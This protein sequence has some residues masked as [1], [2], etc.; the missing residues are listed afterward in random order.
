MNFR[1]WTASVVGLF[2]AMPTAAQ[3]VALLRQKLRTIERLA[4]SP[5]P[6]EN[7]ERDLAKNVAELIKARPE[8]PAAMFWLGDVLER[9]G[10][11]DD[12]LNVWRRSLAMKSLLPDIEINPIRAKAAARVSQSL[13]G[14]NDGAGAETSALQ[15]ME[16]DPSSAAGPMALLESSLRTG[17]IAAAVATIHDAAERQGAKAPAVCVIDHDALSRVGEWAKLATELERLSPEERRPEDYHHFKGRLAEIAG[18]AEE[19][20]LW[21]YLASVGGAESLPTTLRS[22]DFIDKARFKEESAI[23]P[24]LLPYVR[25]LSALDR[26]DVNPDRRTAGLKLPLS[27]AEPGRLAGRYLQVRCA[28]AASEENVEAAWRALLKDYP[29]FPP[30]YCG[31]AE[32]I[33][34]TRPESEE[35]GQLVAKAESMSPTNGKV[36]EHSRMGARFR[37]TK[38]GS[39]ALSV[40]P[41]TAWGRY[42]LHA[43]DEIL[44]LDDKKLADLPA[45]H[46]MAY[47]R[48][49]VGGRVVYRPK[50]FSNTVERDL[51]LMLFD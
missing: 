9:Q 6:S 47:V 27:D 36:R 39:V 30:I 2:A 45:H 35:I 31:L 44:E 34:T 23:P 42:P 33:E 15:S 37:P 10:K 5:K 4:V 17:K 18:R 26:G 7:L 48:L 12:A 24:G 11:R 1:A 32:A 25:A 13:L 14:Q 41:D 28:A 38:E 20:F 8:E 43:G 19:A 40:E 22:R 46:R 16:L 51:E 3:D 29:Y 21:H 50:N 49:F